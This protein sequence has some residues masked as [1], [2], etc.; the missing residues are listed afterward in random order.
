[1][2]VAGAIADRVK[3]IIPVSWD[4]LSR[5]TR[6]GEALLRTA[7]DTKKEEIFGTVV[8]PAIESTYPLIVINYVAK[9]AALDLLPAAIDLWRSEPITVSATGT[10]ENTTYSD[11]VIALQALRT[12][13]LEETRREWPLVKPLVNY[14]PISA[15]AR[16]AIN[17]LNDEF[18]TPSPQEFA[19][20]YRVTERS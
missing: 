10:N 9:L 7:I 3:G 2:A 6:F 11:P 16:P 15:A 8:D 12:N 5:D 14:S 13:L 18:L 20:P 19:R 17:T 4:A 1:M